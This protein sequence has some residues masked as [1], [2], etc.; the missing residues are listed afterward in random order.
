MALPLLELTPNQ[1][2][3]WFQAWHHGPSETST[4]QVGGVAIRVLVRVIS[5]RK[6]LCAIMFCYVDMTMWRD[7]RIIST[8]MSWLPLPIVLSID[9]FEQ[10]YLYYD[11]QYIH[12]SKYFNMNLWWET[13]ELTMFLRGWRLSRGC[14]CLCVPLPRISFLK[15]FWSLNYITILYIIP[16]SPGIYGEGRRNFH[17]SF[18]LAQDSCRDH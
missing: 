15:S 9:I 3:F 7:N 17:V 12:Q 8:L 16:F 6:Q 14:R 13:I 2:S 4:T 1:A 18:F 11:S 10:F 5:I